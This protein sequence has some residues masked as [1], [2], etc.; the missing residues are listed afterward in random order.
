[1][2][3]LQHP[4]RLTLLFLTVT[5]PFG[6]QAG[7]ETSDPC[8]GPGGGRTL[9]V[10][11]KGGQYNKIQSALDNA[12]AGDTV[13]VNGGEYKGNITFK[14]SGKPG[15]CIT[16]KGE[17]GATIKGGSRGLS[18]VNKNYIAVVGMHITNISGG[19]LPTGIWATGSSSHISL[20]NN[21]VEKVLSSENAHGVAF[22]GTSKTP[23]SNIFIDNNEIKNCRLGQS[24]T[25]V[26]NG[27]VKGFMISRNKIHDNDNIGIDIIGFERKGP[28]GQ[29]QA[30]SGYVV[31]NTVYNIT[32]SR[33]PTYG[34]EHS[35]GGIYVDGGTGIMILNNKISNTDIG[36]EVA[37]EHGGTATSGIQV[38]NN[39]VSKSYQGNIMVGGYAASKGRATNIQIANNTLSGGRDGAI[40]MQ[41][42]N[43][44][45]TITGNTLISHGRNH[46]IRTGGN[47]KNI[48]VKGNVYVGGNTKAVA[49]AY[50]DTDG[51]FR[52]LNEDK[53]G[54]VTGRKIAST[55]GKTKGK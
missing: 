43:N 8:P 19:E 26:L 6:A 31:G 54:Q 36:I 35:A 17:N 16:L 14:T 24:E 29:D 22:Y 39:T 34:G 52:M 44:G 7:D 38:S 20:R 2:R 53:S 50:G 41:H 28:R 46:I 30:R 49:K 33:N 37:S 18:I 13:L 9:V 51:T 40:V 45:I 47:N 21:I 10:A 4:A 15:A 25:L 27:N 48:Y 3:A 42:N 5:V 12:K 11:P 1:M 32:C 55:P 23:M